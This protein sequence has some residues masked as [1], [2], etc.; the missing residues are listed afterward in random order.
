M[1]KLMTLAAMAAL[2]IGLTGCTGSPQT[3]GSVL[4]NAATNGSAITG[5]SSSFNL[6][7]A[8]F[9][10]ALTQMKQGFTATLVTPYGTLNAASTG[11][12]NIVPL[13]AAQ[14][15]YVLSNPIASAMY[16]LRNDNAAHKLV[17]Q[18]V[19]GTFTFETFPAGTPL[20]ITQ[21]NTITATIPVTSSVTVTP[22]K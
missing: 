10:L 8:A 3:I 20:T 2:T 7:V 11:T 4:S 17:W 18:G 14:E 22:T 9:N 19:G 21:T 6:D 13:T 16:A 1:K 5:S 12:T 15:A